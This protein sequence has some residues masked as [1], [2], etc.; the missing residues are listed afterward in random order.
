MARDG[1]KRWIRTNGLDD[2]E[3]RMKINIQ[4][5][6]SALLCILIITGCTY[7]ARDEAA[8]KS[9]TSDLEEFGL[10]IELSVEVVRGESSEMRGTVFAYFLLIGPTGTSEALM[11]HFHEEHIFVGPEARWDDDDRIEWWHLPPGSEFV[12][13]YKLVDGPVS[14]RVSLNWEE[15]ITQNETEILR[16]RVSY[17]KP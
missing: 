12:T 13:A 7:E 15:A 6:L 17:T 11:N 4:P 1:L 9:V 3:I 8:W 10:P 2:F 5:A 14:K 16:L